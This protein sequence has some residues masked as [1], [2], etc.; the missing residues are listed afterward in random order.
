M[1]ERTKKLLIE[2]CDNSCEICHKSLLELQI[3]GKV[4]KLCIHHI[5]RKSQGGTDNHRNLMCVCPDCHKKI[6]S[7]EFK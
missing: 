1:K 4:V 2:L 7:Y 6:H 5:R 3:D